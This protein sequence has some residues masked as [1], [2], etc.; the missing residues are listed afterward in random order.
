MATVNR[1]VVLSLRML[2]LVGRRFVSARAQRQAMALTYT[3]ML[4]LVPAFAIMVAVFSMRGLGGMKMRLQTFAIEALSASPEQERLLTQWLGD[5]VSNMQ[6]TGGI[7]GV[8]F[9]V[10]LFF[11]IVSL[12]STLE[13]TL[14]DVWAV[15]RSRSF[16]NK[17]VTYWCIATLGPVFLGLALAQG[18]N[19]ER[20]YADVR[21]WGQGVSS[22]WVANDDENSDGVEGEPE[23][24]GFAFPGV[25]GEFAAEFEAA[26]DENP[27]ADDGA[28]PVDALESITWGT[29]DAG[30]NYAAALL[31][32]L[33]TIITFTLLYAFLPNTRVRFKAALYG[34]IF[35]A[36]LWSGTKW[37]LALSSTTLVRYNTVY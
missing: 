32:L 37:A 24:A 30:A 15:K 22:R 27:L 20:Q 16:I 33:L 34:A 25:G 2:Y 36:L 11:T 1:R 19:I 12:L 4:A 17:F 3:T 10:F 14:N 9:F 29:Q 5:L 23:D 35:S 13:K 6:G 28:G 7:A 26:Q 8:A 21:A 18:A 31:S